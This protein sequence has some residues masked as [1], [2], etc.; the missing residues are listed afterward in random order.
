MRSG[1]E[2]DE[3]GKGKLKVE[4]GGNTREENNA[5]LILIRNLT[6]PRLIKVHPHK[7]VRKL[8]EIRSK[9]MRTYLRFELSKFSFAEEIIPN[10]RR[11]IISGFI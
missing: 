9:E 3:W 2:G 1:K 11:M 6:I 8:F 10:R 5:R 4:F 7:F